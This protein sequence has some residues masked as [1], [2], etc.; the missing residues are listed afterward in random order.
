MTAKTWQTWLKWVG[1]FCLGV[2]ALPVAAVALP[3]LGVFVVLA[4][5]GESAKNLLKELAGD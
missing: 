1:Y 5:F 2:I 3:I 4:K